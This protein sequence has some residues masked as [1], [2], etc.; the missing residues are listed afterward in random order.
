MFHSSTQKKYWI[1]KSE[2]ELK[3]LRK[4]ANSR[5]REEFCT[6]VNNRK[7]GLY[8]FYIFIAMCMYE[9]FIKQDKNIHPLYL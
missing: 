1:F 9:I 2:E 7:I 6:K 5:Y 3:T 4:S 8:C